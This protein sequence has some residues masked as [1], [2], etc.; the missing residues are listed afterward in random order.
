MKRISVHNRCKKHESRFLIM[1]KHLF[2]YA[3][4]FGALIL[5][6]LVCLGLIAWMLFFREPLP[7]FHHGAQLV[8]EVFFHAAV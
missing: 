2:L 1:Q 4:I 6:I 7:A 3:W 8:K 5:G